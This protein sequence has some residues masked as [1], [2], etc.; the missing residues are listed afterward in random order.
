[1]TKEREPAGPEAPTAPPS[2]PSRASDAEDRAEEL[3]RLLEDAKR[4]GRE[5][6]GSITILVPSKR[7]GAEYHRR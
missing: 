2:P 7:I 6:P 4:R 3:Q 1:M 5:E